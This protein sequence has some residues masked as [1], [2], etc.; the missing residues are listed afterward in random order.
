M[1]G[2]ISAHLVAR[3]RIL[4]NESN[5]VVRIAMAFFG[6]TNSAG[7]A[8]ITGLCS[9]GIVVLTPLKGSMVNVGLI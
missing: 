6:S 8:F 5:A 3:A 7:V 2:G 9:R 4:S 1:T